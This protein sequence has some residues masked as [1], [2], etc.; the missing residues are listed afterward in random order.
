MISKSYIIEYNCKKCKKHGCAIVK[1]KHMNNDDIKCQNCGSK[2]LQS[3]I[4][5]IDIIKTLKHKK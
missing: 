5:I 4:S 1:E 3:S 2:L